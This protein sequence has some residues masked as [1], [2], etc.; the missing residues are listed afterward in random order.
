MATAAEKLRDKAIGTGVPTVGPVESVAR[1]D[2]G[3]VPVAASPLEQRINQ[4]RTR[5]NAGVRRPFFVLAIYA[6]LEAAALLVVG[7]AISIIYHHQIGI[8]VS[9][10]RLEQ[11]FTASVLIGMI[12]LLL[13]QANHLFA[14]TLLS[15]IRRRFI[16]AMRCWAFAITSIILAAFALKLSEDFSRGWLLLT[17][18]AGGAVILAGHGILRVLRSRLFDEGSIGERIAVLCLTDTAQ[19]MVHRLLSDR[20]GLFRLVGLYDDRSARIHPEFT[21]VPRHGMVD[22]LI[23]DIRLGLVD[24]VLLCLP[25]DAHDR[26]DMMMRRLAEVS[27]NVNWVPPMHGSQHY[28]PKYAEVSQRP[29]LALSHRPIDNWSAVAKWTFDRCV[30]FFALLL[31]APLMLVCALLLRLESPG[32]ILFRQRRFGLNNQPFEVLKFR[33]M[34]VH[35]QDVSGAARTTRND[36]R[37]TRIGRILRRT[38][39]D[40]LPQLWNVLRG[41]MSV[42]GPRAHAVSMRIGERYYHEEVSEYLTRHRVKPGITGWAQV[43]GS[44]GEVDTIDK[45]RRRVELDLY[46]IQNWSLGLDFYIIAR[47]AMQLF[48]SNQAY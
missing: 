18:L 32:P 45:A 8:A 44:R 2:A 24:T 46:Y 19:E 10:A 40:E 34:Y 9:L 27:V 3:T 36:S 41:E 47:T 29:V 31:L 22:D 7:M 37:V 20:S 35:S 4:A 6:G 38:S 25:W 13:Q 26:L 43:N 16:L 39:I 17:A 28:L 5:A 12:Y 48:T 14:P 23:R 15:S 1:V 42:V 11:Y 21:A 30:A 33:T